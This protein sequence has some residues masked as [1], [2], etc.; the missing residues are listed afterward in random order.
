[1]KYFL[2]LFFLFSFISCN[3]SEN[4][5]WLYT[6]DPGGGYKESGK[7]LMSLNAGLH[8]LENP[9]GNEEVLLIGVH[10]GR[11]EGFEWIY[12]L[13][14]IDNDKTITFFYRWNDGACTS[15]AARN[16]LNY[17]SSLINENTNL[18]LVVL[19]GHSYGGVLVASLVEKWDEA[20][21]IEI[22]SVAGPLAGLD[23][24][25]N[26]QPPTTIAKKVSFYEWRTQHELDGAFKSLKTDPQVINL[27]GSKVTLLPDTYRGR[28]LGHNWSISWVAD[29]LDQLHSVE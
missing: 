4:Y 28:R 10:G 7:K 23:S 24:K 12:P 29:T 15:P 22:H 2:S 5:P 21:P 27:E 16:L 9:S 17:I 6:L 8:P 11:S 26:Y 25:C 1:M 20:L 3:S 13:Q 18:E 14:T 19:V